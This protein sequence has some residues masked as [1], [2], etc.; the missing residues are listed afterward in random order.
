MNETNEVKKELKI[1]G[2]PLKLFLLASLLIAAALIEW[3]HF[4]QVP[5]IQ[6]C[7]QPWHSYLS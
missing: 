7:C 4:S 5:W 6:T 1:N 2:V 3:R